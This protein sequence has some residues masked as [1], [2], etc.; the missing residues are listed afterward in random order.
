MKK[1][2]LPAFLFCI[3]ANSQA[4]LTIGDISIVGFRSDNPDAFSFVTWVDIAP[5]TSLQ[6]WDKGFE[7]GGD[8]SG[9]GAGGGD[10]RTSEGVITWTSPATSI[11]AG[12]VVL[13]DGGVA[14]V[15]NISSTSGS[16]SLAE[17]GDQI[18]AGTGV[19]FAG[20]TLTG[21]LL[22]GIDF[23]AVAGWEDPSD[24]DSA[25]ESALPNVLAVNNFAIGHIDNGEYSESN[26]LLGMTIS[27]FRSNVANSGM[28]T[29]SN[30]AFSL[31]SQDLHLIPEPS[32]YALIFGGFAL[33][34]VI[35]QRRRKSVNAA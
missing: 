16:F 2:L 17:D 34:A 31:S 9:I 27:Q 26:R 7:G 33:G 35:W 18:F 14:D 19:S 29:T 5:S 22:F 23:N 12:T 6:F 3:L 25:Q 28:W 15:G 1:L 24:V 4:Q 21:T 8:G 10:W 13:I 20:S 30:S 32:T 11:S